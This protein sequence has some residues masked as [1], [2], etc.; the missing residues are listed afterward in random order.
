[1]GA[2]RNLR[3]ARKKCRKNI[4]Y[5]LNWPTNEGAQVFVPLGGSF[6]QL[7]NVCSFYTPQ[8]SYT[9][10]QFFRNL[11]GPGSKT[12]KCELYWPSK[13]MNYLI[14]EIRMNKPGSN[15]QVLQMFPPLNWF[16]LWMWRILFIISAWWWY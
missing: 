7:I 3:G 1:M 10:I 4:T 2:W 12:V 16:C 9:P 11:F 14:Y 13:N 6:L 8:I 15:V 5:E